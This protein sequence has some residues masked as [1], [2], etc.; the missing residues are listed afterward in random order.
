MNSIYQQLYTYLVGQIDDTLQL[1]A[2]KL[3]SGNAGWNELNAVG[4]QL[5]NALVTAEEQYLNET[6][7]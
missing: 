5:K 6:E 3:I 4:E 2:E 7:E 1:I